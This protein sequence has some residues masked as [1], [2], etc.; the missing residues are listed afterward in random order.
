MCWKWVASGWS[1]EVTAFDT[2]WTTNTWSIFSS[3]TSSLGS[4]KPENGWIQRRKYT[5]NV[6]YRP[7]IQSYLVLCAL[8]LGYRTGLSQPWPIAFTCTRRKLRASMARWNNEIRSRRRPNSLGNDL[9]LLI[10]FPPVRYSFALRLAIHHSLYCIHPLPPEH[11]SRDEVFEDCFDKWI[12]RQARQ[13]LE[14]TAGVA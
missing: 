1:I 4:F 3:S 5:D 7:Y 2:F 12:E 10:F 8:N 14:S 6:L 9:L 13:N 11:Y